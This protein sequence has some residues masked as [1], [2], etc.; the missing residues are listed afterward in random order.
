MTPKH[1]KDRLQFSRPEV[2]RGDVYWFK[3]VFSDEKR[4]CLD[5][6]DGLACYWH[7]LKT[8]PHRF[9]KCQ[10]EGSSLKVWGAVSF[11]GQ[12]ELVFVQRN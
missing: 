7:D 2:S 3:V 11:Y 5:G 12:T 6:P 4:F 9:S 10:Q 8:E 1:Q